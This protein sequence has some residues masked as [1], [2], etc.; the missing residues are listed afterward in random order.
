[1]PDSHYA[2]YG[3]ALFEL[4][5]ND[6]N[7][8]VSYEEA[9]IHVKNDLKRNPELMSFLSS[10]AI[11]KEKQYLVID[12]IYGK[13]KLEHLAPFLKVLVNRRLFPK[14]DEILLSFKKNAN[15]ALGK[16][17]GI[18]YSAI[19]LNED[20]LKSLEDSLSKKIGKD[21]VLSERVEPSLLGGIKVFIDGKAFD[22][23]L[24]G[25]IESLRK[26][27]LKVAKGSS[28]I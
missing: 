28:G 4:I 7:A 25:K 13:S 27:L 20:E 15:E 9:L 18:V 12:E 8:I 14:F 26:E 23:T 11:A 5:E 22:G 16:E 10:Y 1:M 2:N 3:R 21:V 19:P 17:E 6:K 24:K